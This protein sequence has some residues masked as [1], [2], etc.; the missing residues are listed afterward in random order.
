MTI[1]FLV[2]HKAGRCLKF[3]KTLYPQETLRR[4]TEAHGA[5]RDFVLKDEGRSF[6]VGI[7]D[8]TDEEYLDV[9]QYFL[10][11]RKA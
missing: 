10:A 9:L 8:G 1:P 5:D 6:T 4:F 7:K 2:S 11:V 3:N